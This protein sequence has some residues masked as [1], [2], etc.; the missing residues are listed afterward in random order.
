MKNIVGKCQL[1]GKHGDLTFEHVP[2][3]SAYNNKP[4]YVQ[5]AD[6]LIESSSPRYGKRM[7]NNKGF[8]A[9]TLCKS[10]NNHTGTWYGKDFCDFARQGMQFL[11]AMETPGY[12][13]GQYKIKPL[14]VLKQILTMFMSADKTGHLQSNS[15]LVEFLLLK[16]SQVIP[17][18]LKVFLYSNASSQKRMLGYSVSYVEGLG[19]QKWSEINFQPFGYL[20]AE[21]SGPAHP[22]MI[23]ITDF[24]KCTYDKEHLVTMTTAYLK[25]S[26]MFIGMYG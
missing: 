7:K 3:A 9:Y 16:E 25:V 21:D 24:V 19:I 5:V 13:S 2:P 26:S 12:V 6:H 8:G 14:N 11:M 10:C 17:R 15:Q 20:L 18:N 4:I 23:D 1:C 22:N